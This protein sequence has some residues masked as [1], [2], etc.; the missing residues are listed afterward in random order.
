MAIIAVTGVAT[1]SC[2][3]LISVLLNAVTERPFFRVYTISS[4]YVF[5]FGFCHV[6]AFANV[7]MLKFYESAPNYHR[8]TSYFDFIINIIKNIEKMFM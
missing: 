7:A 6:A 2:S 3:A 8:S 1:L 4:K 5:A